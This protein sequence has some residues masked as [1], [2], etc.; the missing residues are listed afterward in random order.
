MIFFKIIF[1]PKR[2]VVFFLFWDFIDLMDKLAKLYIN[3]VVRL[4]GV[5]I[6][7]VLDRDLSFTSRL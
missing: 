1:W 7:I 4:Y 5:P 2:V 3:E 6:S